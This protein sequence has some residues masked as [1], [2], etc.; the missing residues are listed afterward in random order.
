[1]KRR[2]PVDPLVPRQQSGLA[3]CALC[4][5]E[6][7]HITRHHLIPRSQGGREVVDLCQPCHKTLHSF[8][9]NRTLHA[10][11]HTLHALRQQPDIARYLNW[12]RTQPDRSIRVA[13]RKDQ[14]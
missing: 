8:F 2:P 13:R 1:M 11:L 6:V 9:S 12:I 4:E 3:R 5:R 7:R 10:E 14:R